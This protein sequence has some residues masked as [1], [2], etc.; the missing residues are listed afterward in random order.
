VDAASQFS[1]FWYEATIRPEAKDNLHTAWRPGRF[2]TALLGLPTVPKR[3]AVAVPVSAVLTH[4]GRLLV[5]VQQAPGKF[6]RR[7]VRLLGREGDQAILA[8]GVKLGE[9]VVV[10]Q[11]EVLLSEE[12][13]SQA[14]DQ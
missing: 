13:R 2:V 1:S 4:Q 7:E 10:R 14:E 9:T 12:F 3:P 8:T 6:T 5:Y 11:A